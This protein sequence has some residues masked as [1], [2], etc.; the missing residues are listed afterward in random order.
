[1]SGRWFWGACT[2][3]L[4]ATAGARTPEQAV[5]VGLTAP[6]LVPL[7][8]L[9]RAQATVSRIYGGIGLRIVWRSSPAATW[10]IEFDEHAGE[11]STPGALGYARPCGESG[12]R[13]HI[14]LDRVRKLGSGSSDP[15]T[16]ETSLAGAVLGHVIA[17]ELGHV[18]EGISRHSE[19][20]LMKA[21]WAPH[22]I[23]SMR[24]RPLAFDVADID[25]IY[26]GMARFGRRQVAGK[27]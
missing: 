2:L 22:E 25:L 12:S 7:A 6:Q 26:A 16:G 21:V 8:V 15:V 9:A 10:W 27:Q 19:S 5:V 3:F 1:M 20:G 24:S 14:L 17:H 18:L 13:I 4:A 11:F 23:Y